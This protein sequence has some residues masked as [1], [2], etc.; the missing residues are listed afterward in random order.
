M[1]DL[2]SAFCQGIDA[3]P[4][5]DLAGSDLVLSF[6]AGLA[7]AW[8]GLP[9][10]ARAR[11][12]ESGRTPRWV[13]I[14]ARVSRTA[15]G[16]D[17]WVPIRPGTY[18]ALALGL[19]Y[20]ILKEGL[21]D[22]EAISRHAA[23][24]EDW[25]DEGG[26]KHLGLRRL[27]LRHGRPDFV[28]SRTGIPVPRLVALAKSFGTAEA[29]VAIWDHAVAWRTGGLSDALAI[30]ALNILCGRLNRPG[31]VLVQSPLSLPGPLTGKGLS[32][33]SPVHASWPRTSEQG[34]RA[35]TLLFLYCSNPV[36]SAPDR[37]EVAEAIAQVPLVVSFS[38][39]LDESARH[40][41]LVLPD[42]TYLERWQ[43]ALAPSSVAYPV[44]GVVQPVTPPLHDTRATGDV[45]LDIAGRLGGGLQE[46]TRWSSVEQ[47]VH[48]RGVSLAAARRGSAFVQAFRRK[49]L[50]ELEGRGWWLPHD[51]PAE[52]YWQAILE[53]GGWFDPF[54][55]FHDRSAASQHPDGRV[56]VYP[57]EARRRLQDS[58]QP[59]AEGFLPLSEEDGGAEQAADGPFPLLLLP[60]R[61]LTLASGGTAL[62]P[63]LLEGLGLLTGSSWEVWA[64]VN[65]ETVRE[66]GL[67]PG[68]RV[69]VESDH[70]SFTASVRP[71]AGAQ[72]GVVNVPYGLHTRV[73]GWGQPH[74][75]NPLA[76][77]GNRVDTV[78]GLPDWY[79]ARVRL[80]PA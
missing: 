5:F 64:E 7:E 80:I 72:P 59:L 27:I 6:G 14:D 47:L 11:D 12:G 53:S 31:G 74:Q 57:A 65:P 76:A 19:A 35:P 44:W 39:F 62:M 71:F 33:A 45:L 9:Q 17:E 24:W 67:R 46:L 50:R 15:A 25:T 16:A 32:Q 79:G 55:D 26:T 60:Y 23:G 61:V 13:Q 49:E 75:A 77:V 66:L 18:G 63:W 38:P 48:E 2:I 29:P 22:A 43:D 54:Y 3:P 69:R 30:H 78:T 56:W 21:Y 4:A 73:A 10:A 58:G 42:H 68:Q 1:G 36:A 52:E 70:G 40:A 37:G 51:E 28:S 8:W 41:D 34:A 20:F